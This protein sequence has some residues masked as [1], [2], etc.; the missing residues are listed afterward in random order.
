MNPRNET[1]LVYLVYLPFYAFFFACLVQGFLPEEWARTFKPVFMALAFYVV[2]L[3]LIGLVAVAI[4]AIA[5]A[6][7]AA[8]SR[9][10]EKNP[11]ATRLHGILKFLKY[12]IIGVPAVA[13]FFLPAKYVLLAGAAAGICAAVWFAFKKTLSWLRSPISDTAKSNSNE[14]RERRSSGQ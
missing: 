12:L 7:R 14:N 8:M 11:Q 2:L 13:C 1:L 10:V 4:I 5:L 9:T 6:Y 3:V